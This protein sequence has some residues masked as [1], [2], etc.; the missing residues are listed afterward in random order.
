MYSKKIHMM[1]EVHFISVV[2]LN[3][4]KEIHFFW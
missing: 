4:Q 3:Q 2:K 1:T